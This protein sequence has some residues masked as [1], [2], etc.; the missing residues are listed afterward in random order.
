M[1]WATPPVSSARPS[2]RPHGRP[3]DG[4]RLPGV[5]GLPLPPGRHAAGELSGHQQGPAHS[6]RRA[7]VQ[8]HAGPRTHRSGGRRRPRTSTCL[9]AAAPSHLVQVVGRDGRTVVQGRRPT[10]PRPFENGRRGKFRRRS[11]TSW[12]A[13]TQKTGKP[14]FVRYNPARMHVTTML[15]PKYEAMIGTAGGKDWGLDEAGMK[16][17]R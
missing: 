16:Q 1:T 5:L 13:T 15:S 17:L 2:R 3:P 11:S 4:T 10:H 12:T 14:F 6:R 7:A 8:K 9:D